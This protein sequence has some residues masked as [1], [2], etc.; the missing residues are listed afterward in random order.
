MC[1]READRLWHAA[2]DALQQGRDDA[3]AD[4]VPWQV[5]MSPGPTACVAAGRFRAAAN[6]PAQAACE[7]SMSWH[8]DYLRGR[9][10]GLPPA[11]RAAVEKLRAAR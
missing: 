6:A 10:T 3:R 8:M 4:A 7:A 9:V 2:S 1:R 5:Q 11:M